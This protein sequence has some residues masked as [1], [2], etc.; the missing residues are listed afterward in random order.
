MNA[1]KRA[2]KE[3]KGGQAGLARTL[4]VFPQAVSQWVKGER[5]VPAHHC[6]PIEEATEGAVSRHDLRADVFGPA[7]EDRATA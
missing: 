6:I 3:V 7:P 1:I 5:P 2:V 4:G